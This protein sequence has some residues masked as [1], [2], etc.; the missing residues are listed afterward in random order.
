MCK[1]VADWSDKALQDEVAGRTDTRRT[2]LACFDESYL[3]HPTYK[4][5]SKP[6][7][8]EARVPHT[9]YTSYSHTLWS[10]ELKLNARAFGSTNSPKD[11]L[12]DTKEGPI[13]RGQMLDFANEIMF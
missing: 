11:F 9:A 5:V 12:S 3:A 13:V 7:R 4:T 6:P 2:D 8:D 10:V 1:D